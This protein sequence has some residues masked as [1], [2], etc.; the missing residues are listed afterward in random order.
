MLGIS[1]GV[2]VEI[3]GD[4]I[5]VWTGGP[6][7]PH[8]LALTPAGALD[9]AAQVLRLLGRGEIPETVGGLVE[10]I[11]VTPPPQSGGPARLSILVGGAELLF[12]MTWS[13]LSALAQVATAALNAAPASGKA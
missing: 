6:D 7:A 10:R 4:R 11:S 1:D 9:M 2:R 3:F 12:L 8:G 13:D 5:A